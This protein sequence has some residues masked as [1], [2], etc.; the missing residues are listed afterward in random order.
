MKNY[1]YIVVVLM[2]STSN[3]LFATDYYVNDNSTTGDVYCSAVGDIAN[4]GLSSSSPLPSLS[5]VISIY[6]PSGTGLIAAGDNFYID[7]GTYYQTDVNLGINIDNISI[8]GAGYD[9]T[10]FDHDFGGGDLDR[11]ATITGNGF[12]LSGVYITGYDY[13]VGG[14]SALQIT[15]AT[16]VTITNVM[17]NE[18]Y[19]GGGASAIVVDGGSSVDFI[20]G[21]SN[22]NPGHSSVA[23]GGVNV[24]GNGNTVTFTNYTFS[25][26]GK[27]YQGGSGLYVN[28]DNTTSVTVTNSIFSENENGA[29]EGGGAIYIVNGALLTVNGSCFNDNL[30]N[31]VSSTNYGGA[32][33][34]GRGSTVTIMDCSFSGNAVT[35]SGNG[36]AIAINTGFGSSGSTATVSITNCSFSGN[37]AADGSDLLGRVS[38]SR[39]AVFNVSECSWSGTSDDVRNDNSA[40]INLSNSGSPST[41]GTI[42]MLNTIP[43][44]LTPTTVCPSS[45]APC[46]STLPV[47][48]TSFE[49]KCLDNGTELMWQTVSEYN[50]AFF[51]VE[52]A[53]IDG[54]FEVIHKLPGSLNSSDLLTYYYSDEHPKHGINYYRL[55]QVDVDG[56]SESFAPIT[57]YNNCGDEDLLISYSSRENSL[58]LSSSLEG[59]T[60][61]EMYTLSGEL[62]FSQDTDPFVRLD[63]VKLSNKPK[64]SVYL[65]RF[66]RNG[67]PETGK[68]IVLD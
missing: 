67:V 32:I 53:G 43:S 4:S 20:G 44:V 16:G 15:G 57:V 2:L 34:V 18:N 38:F 29:A 17:V 47:E 21:G 39:A 7:A 37:S 63:R 31:Q 30:S 50:N 68:V 54:Q 13:G 27:D 65:V 19:P 14:A 5:D 51:I 49:G 55:S 56:R 26:N 52:R 42:N 8:I 33:T 64:P 11:W 66:M 24:E 36:G 3:F 10:V 45:P 22:C 23:G 25:A 61:F 59:V 6:G 60:S 9:L 62:L 28:G 41:S 48:L 12:S 40:S 46:F 35:S 1:F 58:Y